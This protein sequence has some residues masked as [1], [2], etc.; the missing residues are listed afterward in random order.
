M[1]IYFLLLFL[2]FLSCQE[3]NRGTE[4]LVQIKTDLGTI[5]IRLYDET[6]VHRDNFIKLINEGFYDDLLFHR[7]IKNFMIQGGDPESRGAKPAQ[8]LGK[9]DPGYTLPA[10]F[11]PS[12]F[13]K[14]GAVA[15]ARQGDDVNPD[16]RSSGSQFYIVQGTRFTEEDLLAIDK[17]INDMRQ[18]N[19]FYRNLASEREENTA[20]AVPLDDNT[21]QQN[22]MKKTQEQLQHT[23]PYRIPDHQRDI[24]KT[25]GGAPHLDG[26]YT[27]FGEV[28][29]GL[30][31]VDRIAAAETDDHAR[32]HHDIPMKI[33]L[34]KK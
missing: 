33:K 13:H 22:A 5:K 19:L 2:F 6:P 17:R 7:V 24:Y 3:T 4:N 8:L 9:G 32:P 14:K 28:V 11:H 18:Q 34:V 25:V 30:D 16:Q 23:A 26:S 10:E 15:A 27:V 12:C 31:V 20:R 29:E 21:L 1:K